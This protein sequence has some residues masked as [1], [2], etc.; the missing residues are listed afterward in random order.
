M[1]NLVVRVYLNI[2]TEAILYPNYTATYSRYGEA[3]MTASTC[4]AIAI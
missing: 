2:T 1:C 4:I 3:C